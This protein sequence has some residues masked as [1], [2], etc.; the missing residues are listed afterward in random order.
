V[1]PSA[2]IVTSSHGAT[3]PRPSSAAVGGVP[4]AAHQ[5]EKPGASARSRRAA[6][7]PGA[8][9]RLPLEPEADP[10]RVLDVGACLGELRQARGGRPEVLRPLIDLGLQ[11]GAGQLGRASIARRS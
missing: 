7:T 1:T 2:S 6:S 8:T 11:S 5:A 10:E 9:T 4:C 3:A